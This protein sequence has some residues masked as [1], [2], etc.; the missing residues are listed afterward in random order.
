MAITYNQLQTELLV[1]LAQSFTPYT[2]I[3]P[4]FVVLFP[5]A[6]AYAEGRIYKKMVFLGTRR[7]DTSLATVAGN[8]T[9]DLSAMA[10]PII[11]SPSRFCAMELSSS[12]P[13]VPPVDGAVLPV[14]AI[15]IMEP[16]RCCRLAPLPAVDGSRLTRRP[17][18][19]TTVSA[20]TICPTAI[21]ADETAE[22]S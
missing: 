22:L 13:A 3:P 7:Q 12:R 10:T 5:Q 18:V 9:L 16:P 4:N 19:V 6:I 15:P 2:S 8:R 14:T 20:T 11:L 17:P 1:A 21:C